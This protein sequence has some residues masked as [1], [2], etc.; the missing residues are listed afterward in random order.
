[1]IWA[2]FLASRFV[3]FTYC[4]TM[5]LLN[6]CFAPRE[7]LKWRSRRSACALWTPLSRFHHK[8]Q[9]KGSKPSFEE[10]VCTSFPESSRDFYWCACRQ[11]RK[12][13][14]RSAL[15]VADRPI[16]IRMAKYGRRTRATTQERHLRSTRRPPARPIQPFIRAIVMMGPQLRCSILF[17]WL[18]E[19][20]A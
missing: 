3:A 13:N 7:N 9:S 5:V 20:V 1:L 19:A 10:E 12:R 15:T 8:I 18:T 2:S 16:P 17:R 4:T 14:N 6:S 11:R